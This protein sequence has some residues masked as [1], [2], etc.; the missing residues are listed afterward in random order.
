MDGDSGRDFNYNFSQVKC[1]HSHLSFHQNI[2]TK[3]KGKQISKK[4]PNVF[5]T[6]THIWCIVK[7]ISF[8]FGCY[9]LHSLSLFSFCYF[10]PFRGFVIVDRVLFQGYFY[11][12]CNSI[13]SFS[14]TPAAPKNLE[15]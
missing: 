3:L 15:I 6:H 7:K 13:W 14:I 1:I 12:K 4:G 11:C 2:E 9:L 5:S 10:H 8:V